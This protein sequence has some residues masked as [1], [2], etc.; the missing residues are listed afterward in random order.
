MKKTYDEQA[1]YLIYNIMTAAGF[2]VAEFA[3]AIGVT[4]SCVRY[5]LSGVTKPSK[6]NWTKILKYR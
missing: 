2:G 4:E 6:K 5:W 1:R 3:K